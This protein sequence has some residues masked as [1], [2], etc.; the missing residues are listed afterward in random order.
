MNGALP[1]AAGHHHGTIVSIRTEWPIE[2]VRVAEHDDVE[3]RPARDVLRHLLIAR[4]PVILECRSHGVGHARTLG[5]RRPDPGQLRQHAL[6]A[7]PRAT[8]GGAVVAHGHDLLAAERAPAAVESRGGMV[9]APARNGSSLGNEAAMKAASSARIRERSHAGAW[10]SPSS[11]SIRNC[12][13]VVLVS[14]SRNIA[15]VCRLIDATRGGD[16]LDAD[17]LLR[18]VVDNRIAELGEI[19]K[20]QYGLL[21]PRPLEVGAAAFGHQ[22]IRPRRKS[23]GAERQLMTVLDVHTAIG[24]LPVAGRGQR[25]AVRRSRERSNRALPD[26]WNQ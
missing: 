8:N 25:D 15:P 22:R 7:P 2:Q 11:R 4:S 12:C 21:S 16:E 18:D 3:T 1:G 13:H 14:N 17:A 24:R 5:N 10:T 20:R 23:I 9:L 6:H 26:L 19:V